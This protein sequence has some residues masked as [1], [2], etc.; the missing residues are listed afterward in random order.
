[1]PIYHPERFVWSHTRDRALQ[2]CPRQYYLRYH[3]AP[4]GRRRDA[5]RLARRAFAL[6]RLVSLPQA[7]GTVVHRRAREVAE[8]ALRCA[9]LP[10]GSELIRRTRG[11]LGVLW[12]SRCREEFLR[13]PASSGMLIEHYYRSDSAADCAAA[14]VRERMEPAHE[15]LLRSP[16]WDELAEAGPAALHAL[17]T[18]LRVRTASADVWVAPDLVYRGRAGWTVIDWKTGATWGPGEQLAVYGFYLRAS[19]LAPGDPVCSARVSDLRSGDERVAVLTAAD[20]EGVLDR[21]RAST[22]DMEEVAHAGAP[23]PP[24]PVRACQSCAFRELCTTASTDTQE[25]AN[26]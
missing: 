13:S 17:D 20:L 7:F 14:T 4:S 3:L 19:G 2:D 16:I 18:P 8:S 11:A 12:R 26:G 21:I 10:S 25:R 6:S 24:Q 22:A 9:P 15:N 1:M 5:P 23:P